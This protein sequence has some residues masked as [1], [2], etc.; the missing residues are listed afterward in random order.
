MAIWMLLGLIW[1]NI[2]R[3][4]IYL[5]L[6][7][8]RNLKLL[9]IPAHKNDIGLI[10]SNKRTVKEYELWGFSQVLNVSYDDLFS[11]IEAKLENDGWYFLFYI[12]IWIY[13]NTKD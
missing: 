5:R 2:E 4:I 7:L 10:E 8:A 3:K 1:L 9:G 12:V 11:G 6:G 13:C